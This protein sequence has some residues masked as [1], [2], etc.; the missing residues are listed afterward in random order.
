MRVLE[1][2]EPRLPDFD[3]LPDRLS[4]DY[5][6]ETHQSANAPALERLT[7]RYRIVID[8]SWEPLPA[9]VRK[10]AGRASMRPNSIATPPE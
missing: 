1:R 6:F 3:E 7:E 4:A 8:G 5:V 10:P 2:T 9:E